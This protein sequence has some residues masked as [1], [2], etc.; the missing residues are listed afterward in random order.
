MGFYY[1][2][3]IATADIAFKAEGRTIEDVFIFASEALIDSMVG[4][5]HSIQP[6]VKRKIQIK[7]DSADMLL[8]DF[9][10]EIIYYKDADSLLL[11]VNKLAIK[12][13]NQTYTLSAQANGEPVDPER[14]KLKADVKAVTLHKFEVKQTD[15]GWQAQVVLDI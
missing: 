5:I 3:D 9:L 8:F 12:K 13:E 1:L 7:Q 15:A 11:V 6:K 14:H 10:Q 2:D 4:D